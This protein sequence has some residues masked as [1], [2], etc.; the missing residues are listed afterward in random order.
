MIETYRGYTIEVVSHQADD[1]HL[2]RIK[3]TGRSITDWR[4]VYSNNSGP[5]A[6][7]WARGVIDTWLAPG[8]VLELRKQMAIAR[9]LHPKP[10]L[11]ALIEEV[12]EVAKAMQEETPERVK[13]KLYQVAVAALLFAW[14]EA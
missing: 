8:T 4:H 6:M 7:S 1:C 9:D 13:E 10:S 3:S 14:E 5:G 2:V 11:A 12:G